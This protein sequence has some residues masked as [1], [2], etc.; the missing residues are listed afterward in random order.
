MY[1]IGSHVIH[2]VI[3]PDDRPKGG[4][5]LLTTYPHPV[6]QGILPNNIR[7]QIRVTTLIVAK[8]NVERVCK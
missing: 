7:G 5:N 3:Q 8:Q 4:R 6:I 2:I 1:V